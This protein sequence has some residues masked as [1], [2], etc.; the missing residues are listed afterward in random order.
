MI[1]MTK[2]G[3]LK[4]GDVEVFAQNIEVD[5][6]VRHDPFIGE[7]KIIQVGIRPEPIVA[8]FSTSLLKDDPERIN[9]FIALNE[10]TVLVTSSS[11]FLAKMYAV[12]KWKY[13][14]ESDYNYA[15]YDVT[16]TEDSL[17]DLP[18]DNK[19]ITTT[20]TTPTKKTTLNPKGKGR[21]WIRW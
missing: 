8:T 15:K 20:K 14:I 18:D 11:D 9:K 21:Y 4:L 10:K 12:V 7:T 3:R 6:P 17:K 2:N 13:S 1:K 5:D 16:L 19:A